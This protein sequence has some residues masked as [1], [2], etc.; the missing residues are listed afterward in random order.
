[1]KIYLDN[2]CY[3]R[4]YDDLSIDRNRVESEAV[5]SII[6][7][8]QQKTIEIIGS[9]IVD[10][11]MKH[12]TDSESKDKVLQLYEVISA[13]IKYN[14]DILKRAKE[15][16]TTNKHIRSFDSLHLASA[17]IGNADI[18]LTTDDKFRKNAKKIKSS[19]RVM[20]PLEYMMEVNE[21]A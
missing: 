5:L 1:M 21:N 12:S 19:V 3:N 18:L 2:C 16:L 7:M 10:Y 20:N 15:I 4:P 8:G 13:K 14:A 9:S 11:E 6:K 17:E